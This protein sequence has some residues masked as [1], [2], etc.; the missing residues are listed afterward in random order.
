[1]PSFPSPTPI[2][3]R[4]DVHVGSVW[5]RASERDATAVDVRPTDPDDEGD[6]QA[7]EST[8]IEFAEGELTVRS[9]R[10]RSWLDRRGSSVDVHIDLPADSNLDV[11]VA[12]GDITADGRFGDC[13]LKTGLG[14]INLEEAETLALKNGAGDTT[15]QRVNGHADI[16]AGTG[17]VAVAELGSTGVLKNSNGATWVGTAHGEVRLRAA[18][19]DLAIERAEAGIVAKAANG[20]VRLESAAGLAVLETQVGD[21]DVGIP[22]GTAAWLDVDARAGAVRNLLDE[23]DPPETTTAAVEIRARTTLGDVVIRRPRGA[24]DAR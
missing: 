22:A 24:I 6:A 9:S 23:I 20:D 16:V 19:G 5:I 21:V 3:L 13:R 14:R 18:N 10:L 17:D 2:Q 1:M 15:V 8:R 11:T 7:A 4:L 12:M